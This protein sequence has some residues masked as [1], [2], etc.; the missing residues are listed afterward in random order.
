MKQLMPFLLLVGC[1]MPFP[2]PGQPIRTTPA[3]PNGI[4]VQ[5][6]SPHQNYIN[7][8]LDWQ[9]FVNGHVFQKGVTP[10]LQ[11]LSG[12][13]QTIRLPLKPLPPNA[14]SYLT[15]SYHPPLRNDAPSP[16][17]DLPPNRKASSLA[18][19]TLRWTNWTGDTYVPGAGELSFTDSNDLFTISSPQLR[20]TFDKQTGWIQEYSVDH[21]PLLT[22]SNGLR[23]ALSAPPHLQLFSTS[24]G[25]RMA[26]IRTEYTVP[27]LSC[28]LHLS[29]TLNAAGTM[30]VE[31]TL[32]TDTTRGDSVLHPIQRFGMN[33][34]LA[35]DVDSISAY[36]PT[37]PTDTLPT[38]H[39]S[40]LSTTPLLTNLRTCDIYNDAGNGF[41]L[42]ADSSFLQLHITNNV[43]T[44]DK[45]C[46][47]I[48]TPLIYLHYAFKIAPLSTIMH[49]S[50]TTI[51]YHPAAKPF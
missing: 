25:P 22:D 37:T 16:H 27:E 12:R 23:P 7:I 32:E 5:P 17:K 6:D 45:I 41:Q 35:S 20:I 13:P 43:L 21:L 15:V 14:E 46:N 30:A 26:I 11:L 28:L 3:P 19:Q 31:Q 49:H 8:T 10:G 24:T 4:R 51:M 1:G 44:I 47:P 40:A 2:V 38:I 29:Y 33:W 42:T 36:S 48:A 39:Q 50:A 34:Q 9:L 18:A